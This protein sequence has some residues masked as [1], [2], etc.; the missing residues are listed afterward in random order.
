MQIEIPTW[1]LLA[2]EQAEGGGGILEA[3]FGGPFSMIFLFAFL[4]IMF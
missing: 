2:Q 4:G 1:I 3:L